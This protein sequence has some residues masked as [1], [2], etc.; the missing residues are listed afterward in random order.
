MALGVVPPRLERV[1]R[2]AR[3]YYHDHARCV[4]CDVL[5]HEQENGSRIIDETATFASWVPFAATVP[6][7]IWIVPKTHQASFVDMDGAE[8]INL[9]FLMRRVLRRL[10]AVHGVRVPY[11]Y[12]VDSACRSDISA[13]HFHWRMRIAPCTVAWGGFELA[14]R[15]PINPSSPEQDAAV[16]RAANYNAIG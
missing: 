11:N 13:P 16:L 14:T 6:F 4:I 8:S 5:R 1:S 2:W 10:D 12:A 3:Q 9:G 7:E 15:M